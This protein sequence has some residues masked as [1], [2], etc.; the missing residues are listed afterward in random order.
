MSMTNVIK[1]NNFIIYMLNIDDF[2]DGRH[3]LHKMFLSGKTKNEFY[4]L[5]Y[6]DVKKKMTPIRI[7]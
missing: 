3:R 2:K 5:D 6:T 1:E 7:F 4:V